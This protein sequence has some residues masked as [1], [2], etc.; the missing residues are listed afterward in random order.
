M[1]AGA[2]VTRDVPAY[3]IDL[4]NP[5]RIAGYDTTSAPTTGTL[6]PAGT[7]KT[8]RTNCGVEIIPFR[9]IKYCFQLSC[10][11]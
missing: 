8:G 9:K 7:L 10:V 6:P 4:G 11:Q 3:S 1:D 2:V 5:A